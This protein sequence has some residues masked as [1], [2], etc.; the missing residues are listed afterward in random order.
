LP[1]DGSLRDDYLVDAPARTM[2]LYV[3]G[4]S[5]HDAGLLSG[6]AVEPLAAVP[7]RQKDSF[8]Q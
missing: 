1:G 2:L 7:R 8:R 3:K 6:D 5:M 4:E